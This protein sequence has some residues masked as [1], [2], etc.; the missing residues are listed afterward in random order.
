M[1]DP[2]DCLGDDCS[3]GRAS[4][5]IASTRLLMRLSLHSATTLSTTV[6]ATMLAGSTMIL[7]I[8]VNR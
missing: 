7:W 6:M 5:V 2:C 1:L 4:E 3:P 8:R